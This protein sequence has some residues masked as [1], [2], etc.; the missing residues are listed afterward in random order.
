MWDGQFLVFAQ[1]Y[2]VIRFDFWGF[3][4]STIR[5]DPFFLHEDLYELLQPLRVEQAHLVGCSLGGRASIDLALT[6]PNVVK[7]LTVVG[8]E[9]GGYQFT[10]EGFTRFVE[11]LIAA[12]EGDDDAREIELKLQLWVDG[13][14][15]TPDQVDAHVRERARE[16][17]LVGTDYVLKENKKSSCQTL[18]TCPI[19]K[20]QSSSITLC[21]NFCV[22][23]TLSCQWRVDPQRNLRPS[24]GSARVFEAVSE[25]R[26]FSVSRPV[27]I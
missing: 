6:Y 20:N 25:V 15:R 24:I 12:R 21:W 3:G 4:K 19:W 26:Q 17:L 22:A 14:S 1:G 13:T 7:S 5:H 10:G 23:M 2:R 16:M 27:G 9:L 11:Q 18:L 8:S